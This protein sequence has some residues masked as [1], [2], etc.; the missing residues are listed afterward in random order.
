[1]GDTTMKDYYY[2]YDPVSG[3]FSIRTNKPYTM[4][5]LP[6]IVKNQLWDWQNYR[7]NIST[8]EPEPKV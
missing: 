3:E 2:Y 6:Y 4:T 7:V 8:G 1:M 5:D